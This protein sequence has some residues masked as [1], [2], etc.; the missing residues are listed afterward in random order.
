MNQILSP[1][2]VDKAL[3]LR[4]W[5]KFFGVLQMVAGGF[6]CLSLVGIVVGWL[7]ILLGWTMFKAGDR[8]GA[9]AQTSNP[10]DLEETIHNLR[11]HYMIVG[12]MCVI[13]FVI[14]LC[15]ILIY[16]LFFG[17]IAALMALAGIAGSV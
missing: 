7:P 2:G 13:T 1:S 10:A 4:F 17:G 6:Y 15:F 14:W 5:L 12:I 3:S 11:L 8:L 9:F 16:I